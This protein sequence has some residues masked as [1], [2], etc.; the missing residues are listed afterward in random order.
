MNYAQ[1][2]DGRRVIVDTSR[3]QTRMVEDKEFFLDPGHT[4][5]L[6]EG[7]WQVVRKSRLKIAHYGNPFG[8]LH[9]NNNR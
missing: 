8:V 1:L 6:L 5:V 3:V 7:R 4:L 2:D 9:E